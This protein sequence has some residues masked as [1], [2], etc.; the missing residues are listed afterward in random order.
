MSL[1]VDGFVAV[2]SACEYGMI[3]PGW[4]KD[5]TI[6]VLSLNRKYEFKVSIP[7][8][9]L[10]SSFWLRRRFGYEEFTVRKTGGSDGDVDVVCRIVRSPLVQVCISSSSPGSCS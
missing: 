2:F 8:K 9:S 10:A 6:S 3:F 5:L 1:T 4:E 7:P